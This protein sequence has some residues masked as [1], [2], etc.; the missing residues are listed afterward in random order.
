[1]HGESRLRL[2][3]GALFA[4][5]AVAFIGVNMT[6]MLAVWPQ[7]RRLEHL[8]VNLGQSLHL[9]AQMRGVAQDLRSAAMTSVISASQG[10]AGA[11]EEASGELAKNLGLLSRLAAA[12]D[13][14]VEAADESEAWSAIR[15]GELPLLA[16]RAAGIVESVRVPGGDSPVAVEEL[17][18]QSKRVDGLFQQLVHVNASQVQRSAEGIDAALR[19]LLVLCGLLL[20]IGGAGA[21]LLFAKSLSLIRRYA[22]VMDARLS[23]LD[24]FA[25]RV[26]HDLRSPL[27]TISLSLSSIA[28]RAADEAVRATADKAQGGVRRLSAMIADL[29]EFA[30]SGA[31]PEPG[32]SVELPA[33]FDELREELRPIADGAGVRLTLDAEPGLLAAASG[34]AIRG[35]VANL[36]ENG[37]KYMREGGDRTVTAQARS[38]GRLVHI[39]VR[40]TGIGIPRDRLPT[41]FDPFVRAR[42]RRDSYGLGLATVK[43]LVDAHSGTVMVESEGGVG[44]VF[45]VELPRAIDVATREASDP[46]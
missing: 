33:V 4:A 42:A 43:R 38:Q 16:T 26:A 37:V 21:V 44:T 31:T 36:V 25:S 6:V 15:D 13:P 12:Y 29:L 7:V 39:E 32:V 8:H 1:M 27:Q 19:R 14:L 41:I 3:V 28:K 23:E 11:A 5:I 22:T 40:D 35:I 46:C 10:H 24:A 17:R 45:I 34:F 30:R 2:Q 18:S 20:V 9:L